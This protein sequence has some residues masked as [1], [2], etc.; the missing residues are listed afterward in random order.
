[1]ATHPPM[2]VPFVNLQIEY[3]HAILLP[4]YARDEE[5]RQELSQ[6]DNSGAFS[7]FGSGYPE[8]RVSYGESEF[9]K[10]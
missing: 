2:A 9:D 8:N 10:K 4:R 7:V 1:M 5:C 3:L 6:R